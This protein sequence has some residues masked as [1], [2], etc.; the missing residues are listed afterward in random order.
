MKKSR[1]I[2]VAVIVGILVGGGEVAALTY[3]LSLPG[4]RPEV[5]EE[6]AAPPVKFFRGMQE[7]RAIGPARPVVT[8]YEEC[9][10]TGGVL[11]L[12]LPS[13]C[14]TAQGKIFTNPAGTPGRAAYDCSKEKGTTEDG[15]TEIVIVCKP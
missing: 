15:K 9:V 2:W 6:A 1:R 14:M 10:N 12:S 3:S 8:S 7:A 5:A 13:K 4:S 11:L